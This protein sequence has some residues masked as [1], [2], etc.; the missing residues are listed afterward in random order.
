MSSINYN[1]KLLNIHIQMIKKSLVG[2]EMLKKS[3]K[4]KP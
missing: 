1:P 4:F 2:N 3:R